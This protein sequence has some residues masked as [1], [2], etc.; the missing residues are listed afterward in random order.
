MVT[1]GEA[2]KRHILGNFHDPP[3]YGHPG[4][5]RTIDLVERH[6][7]WP[8]LRRD[9]LQYVKGC[10][11]CQR[12][13]VN[14]RPTKAPLQPIFPKPEA[15]P[16][17]VIAVDFITKLPPSQ[18]Y[19]SILTVTDHD[20]TKTA[21]FIPCNEAITS[22]ETAAVF[23]TQVF[24]RFGLPSKIISD[25]DP[26]FASKFT[27]EVCRILGIA[28]NISTAYH[29][30]TDG[31][32]ERNNQWVETYLRFFVNHQQDDWV[33]YLPM[34]EFAHNNW[35]SETTRES[36]FHLLMG[37]HPC[38]DWDSAQ[39]AMPQVTKRLDQLKEARK[40]AQELM[41]QVQTLWIKHK[42]TPKYEE[43]DMVWLDGHNIK[44]EQ[45]AAK[46]A[47]RR[48]GPFPISQVMSPVTY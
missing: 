5:S 25:W 8:G 41:T 39:T 43:G 10:A 47:P 42:A 13:K 23:V 7:W 19:D 14:T 22:E 18:G 32:S 9:A 33:A 34:A 46:L 36:P 12:R 2:E 26:R 3:V 6:Y 29:P 35:R 24:K 11:E 45:P 40:T 16:F 21:L 30:R 4:I 37:Y 17:E 28:Q 38:A 48:H 20:C 31:Q 27:R 15:A 44:T 1:G